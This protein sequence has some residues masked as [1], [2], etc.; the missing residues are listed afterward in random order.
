MYTS[1][2]STA[3]GSYIPTKE[4]M[5]KMSHRKYQIYINNSFC[6]NYLLGQENKIHCFS[7]PPASVQLPPGFYFIIIKRTS[8]QSATPGRP[9]ALWRPI[10]Q[11]AF[12]RAHA[13]A[14]Y[15]IGHTFSMLTGHCIVLRLHAFSRSHNRSLKPRST[16]MPVSTRAFNSE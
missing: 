11:F 8:T 6:N 14:R 16:T 10:S 9:G 1:N 2:I 12:V 3:I 4:Q 13:R 7:G 15:S 5:N